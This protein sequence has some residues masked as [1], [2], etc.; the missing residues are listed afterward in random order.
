MLGN[1]HDAALRFP[2]LSRRGFLLAGGAA[3][4]TFRAFSETPGC[5]LTSEQEE[6]PY[7]I[8]DETMRRD[9][10]EASPGVPLLL[11]IKLVDATRC[12]PLLNAAVDIWH[13]DALGVYSG[14]TSN[15]P[16]GG[17]GGR[18]PGG[19]RGP[20][21]PGGRPPGPPPEFRDGNFTGGPPPQGLGRGGQRARQ[22]DR[23]A[24]CAACN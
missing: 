2:H 22:T 3:L 18:G 15:S 13:C 6:G 24:S 9:I 10:T 8:D 21:A 7:Y 14:F 12:A 19:P 4:T 17:P 1:M 16:D 23:P 20:G 5:T 11:D